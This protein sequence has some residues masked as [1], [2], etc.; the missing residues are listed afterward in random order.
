MTTMKDKIKL[1]CAHILPP[2][3]CHVHSLLN[4]KEVSLHLLV[5]D[6]RHHSIKMLILLIF[7]PFLSQPLQSRRRFVEHV[8][9]VFAINQYQKIGEVK[10]QGTRLRCGV[11]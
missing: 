6:N 4:G 5:T 8:L 7:V 11:G 9:R 10:S 2:S 3:L 1:E